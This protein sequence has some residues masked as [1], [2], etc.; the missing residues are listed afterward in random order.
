MIKEFIGQLAHSMHSDV[1]DGRIPRS[2]VIAL[3][4]TSHDLG[5]VNV[6]LQD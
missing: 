2:V 5:S 3:E 4:E 1:S 6:C